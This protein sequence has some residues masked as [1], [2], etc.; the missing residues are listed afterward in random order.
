MKTNTIEVLKTRRSRYSLTN[1]S[2]L[3]N[4]ELQLLLS[5][6]IKLTPSA[7]NSQAGRVVLLLNENHTKFWNIV[8]KQPKEN[9][10]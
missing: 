3:T 5:K 2:T 10:F 9:S 8:K 4:E 7:F 1:K 6:V